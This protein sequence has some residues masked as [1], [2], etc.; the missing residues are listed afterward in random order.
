MLAS[1]PSALGSSL[2]FSKVYL[3]VTEI[4]QHQLEK[5]DN[6]LKMLIELIYNGGSLQV[7]LS[8]SKTYDP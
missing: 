7:F 8:A 3:D 2:A 1:H 6:G 4:Y 5:V